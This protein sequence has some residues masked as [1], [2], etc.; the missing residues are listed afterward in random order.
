[1]YKIFFGE[2]YLLITDKNTNNTNNLRHISEVRNLEEFVKEFDT[3]VDLKSYTIVAEKPGEVFDQL[4]Q[5]FPCIEAG[6]GV[7][8]NTKG[9]ILIIFR[10]GKWDLPKGKKEK[11]EDF[12]ECALREVE[13]E[14]GIK[15]HKIVSPII[16]TFHT[17]KIKQ[18]LFMKHTR[19]FKMEYSGSLE[20]TPQ[21]EEDISQAIWVH[22]RDM[23]KIFDN[24][25]LSLIH[26]SEPTRR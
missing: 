2:R 18:K 20:C 19:W 16:D 3:F 21:L 17:Y 9:E 13:E 6:G 10:Y 1:M 26:I 24:T 4:K 25:Y 7:V 23:Q 22:P 14:C 12:A 8:E 11:N 15:G 5:F